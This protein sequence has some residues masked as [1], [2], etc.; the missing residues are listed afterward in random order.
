MPS[1]GDVL[2]QKN[3]SVNLMGFW[4]AIIA[5]ASTLLFALFFA[6]FFAH[7]PAVWS[8]VNAYFESFNQN[9]YLGWVIPC[10]ILALTFPLVSLCI[11]FITRKEKLIFALA[12]LIFAVMYGAILSAN[13]FELAT[14]FRSA[15]LDQHTEAL[16]WFVIGSPFS[17]TNSLEGAGYGFMSLSFL[18]SGFAFSGPGIFRTVRW[19]LIINGISGLLGVLLTALSFTVISMISLAVWCI[20]FPIS[21]IMIAVIFTKAKQLQND[22]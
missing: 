18:F 19:L 9:L 7:I 2:M 3:N 22:F 8:G 12:G 17:I 6:L 14:V 20:T 16:E 15:I 21:M 5:T 10:L 4:A 11:C 13:Y 1:S